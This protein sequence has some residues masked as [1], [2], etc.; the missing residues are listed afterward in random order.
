MK[1][2][3]LFLISFNFFIFSTSASSIDLTI[4]GG[5]GLR[6]YVSSF[7]T[8][9]PEAGSVFVRGSYFTDRDSEIYMKASALAKNPDVPDTALE[10]AITSYFTSTVNIRPVRAAE[11]LPANSKESELRLGAAVLQEIQILRFLGNTAAVGRHEGILKFITDRGN[12]TRRDIETHY[13]QHIGT[14]VSSIVDEEFNKI[15]FTMGSPTGGFNGVLT[16]NPQNGQ[17]MLSYEGYFNDND[18]RQTKTLS[19][20]TLDALSSVMSRNT[21]EFSQNGINTVRTQAALIPAVKLSDRALNEIKGILTNFY[22]T[23]N[24]DTYNVVRDV[25]F[26]YRTSGAR[27]RLN[28]LRSEEEFF[29]KILESCYNTLASMNPALAQRVSRDSGA[30]R[31]ITGLSP[32]QHRRLLELR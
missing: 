11:L 29:N 9:P 25:Y 10:F 23:P 5:F 21:S 24:D 31:N 28:E 19:A 30:Q 7:G 12:V 27:A 6:E 16:R 14:L 8:R 4:G 26:V 20:Q 15:S 17:Y 13:S 18:G 32:D 2:L 1:K 22:R 3:I